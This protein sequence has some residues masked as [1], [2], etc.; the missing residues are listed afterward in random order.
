L[1]FFVLFRSHSP[2]SYLH[3]FQTSKIDTIFD[4]NY[5]CLYIH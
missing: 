5:L 3:E 4:I 1:L 2:H